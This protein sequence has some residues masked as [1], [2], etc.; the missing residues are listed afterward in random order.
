MEKRR[1]RESILM[2]F[3]VIALLLLPVFT[4]AAMP[5]KEDKKV[6]LNLNAATVKEFFAALRQ[7]TGLSFVYNTNITKHIKPITIH[8]KDETVDNVLQKVLHGTE[9]YYYIEKDI[10]TIYNTSAFQKEATGIRTVTG[11]VSD[12]DGIPLPGVNIIIKSLKQVAITDID[13]KYSIGVSPE[14][15]SILTFSYIGMST[16]EVTIDSGTK[17]VV[18]N[19]ILKTDN[20]LKEVIV[21]GIYTRK[22]ESFTGA[23]TTI[24]SKDLIRVGN[25][26]VLQSLKNLDPTVYIPDNLSMGSDPNSVPTMSMRGTS[27]FP[28]TESSSLKSNYQNQ[29]NQPLF[30]LDGFETTAEYVMDMDM[31]RIESLTILKDASAKAL[32]GSKAANGVIVIETKRLS[33]D[34]Q[35]ITYNGSISLEMPD[36]SSYNLTNALEKLE[37][38]RLDGAYTNSNINLQENLTR[39]YNSRKKLVLEG[40]D[41]YWLSK[42]LHT[43]I[44]HKHNLSIELGNSQ[45][46]RAIFRCYLQSSDRYHER[47][48]PSQYI[49]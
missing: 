10:V 30:I 49:R 47:L 9:F 7:Q 12:E 42:P 8:V 27:S 28:N 35:R 26:N 33:G 22:A 25:Q 43:G 5:G 21:T 17:D 37:V 29:P 32:Y 15:T 3:L 20:Q 48:R 6:T 2:L 39:L 14:T 44:G 16:L 24:T 31:N 23:S 11:I 4:F 18:K 41:T 13:G 45:N 40:L 38:E 1:G 46:L 34:E 19:I 36:L